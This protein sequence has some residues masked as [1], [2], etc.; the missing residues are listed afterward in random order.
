MSMMKKTICA[1]L[2]ALFL[3]SIAGCGND[4]PGGSGDPPD[5]T[6][7]APSTGDDPS[8]PTGS[9]TP[10][11]SD[12]PPPD[13][14]GTAIPSD[15]P[16]DSSPPPDSTDTDTQG[17]QF[18]DLSDIVFW[19]SSGAGAWSTE[20]QIND[21]GTFVGYFHDS[22]MGDDGPDYPDGTLYECYFSGRF[23]NLRETGA[24]EYAMDCVSLVS[25]GTYGEEV[26]VNGLRVI[27]SYPYGFDDADEFRLYMPGKPT[28]EL[29]ENFL[30][31]YFWLADEETLGAFV[32]YNI[33]A[34]FGFVG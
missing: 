22:D 4:I 20:V 12:N 1:L 10:P 30:E 5:L 2:A 6:D 34:G 16:T 31:W 14:S 9:D 32:L 26:I 23:T 25:E 28:A 19:F 8:P 24:F 3:F 15:P 29:P 27:T 13:T 33:A 7:S 17:L 11:T 18:S 21:D